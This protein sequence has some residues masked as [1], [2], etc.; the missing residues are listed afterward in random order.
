MGGQGVGNGQ[1]EWRPGWPP[2]GEMKPVD[3]GDWLEPEATSELPIARRDAPVL[4][5]DLTEAGV[6]DALPGRA[7]DVEE[8]G[9]EEVIHV[10]LELEGE[11]EGRG[12][13]NVEGAAQAQLD[14]PPA[15]SVQTGPSRTGDVADFPGS[16]RFSSGPAGVGGVG[17]IR[18]GALEGLRIDIRDSVEV[19][20]V[21]SRTAAPSAIDAQLALV[22]SRR[23]VGHAGSAADGVGH[24]AL[25]V[26]DLQRI[27][28]AIAIDA[29]DLPASADEA[30]DAVG[31]E[32]RLPATDGEGID[33]GDVELV[34]LVVLPQA[35]INR[36]GAVE[37]RKSV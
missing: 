22:E 3:P 14:I 11:G 26:C 20:G 16:V 6:A 24:A 29:R 28:I 5:V 7:V 31:R 18:I 17:R 19:D 27:S 10:R 23:V 8:G 35:A 1:R 34:G 32:E 9:V 12:F 30:H 33:P 36:A 4:T 25:V 13:T 2:F 37:D 21:G 15:G